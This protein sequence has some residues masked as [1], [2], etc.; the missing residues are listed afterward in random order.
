MASRSTPRLEIRQAK[1]KDVRA[2]GELV[3]RA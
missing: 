3:R 1:L 2:I